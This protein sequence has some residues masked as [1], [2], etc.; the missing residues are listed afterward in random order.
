MD[1]VAIAHCACTLLEY[2]LEYKIFFVN[3]FKYSL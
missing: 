3:I 2:K 1:N